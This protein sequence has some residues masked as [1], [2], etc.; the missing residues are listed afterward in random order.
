MKGWRCEGNEGGGGCGGWEWVVVVVVGRWIFFFLMGFTK[1]KP[2]GSTNFFFS[3]SSTSAGEKKNP[4]GLELARE[5][6]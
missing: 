2:P 1:F 6:K 3:R 5:K 4:F